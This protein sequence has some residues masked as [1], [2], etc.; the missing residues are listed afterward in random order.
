VWNKTLSVESLQLGAVLTFIEFMRTKASHKF[1]GEK[2]AREMPEDVEALRAMLPLDDVAR[3]VRDS[4][5]EEIESDDGKTT[6]F[7]VELTSPEELDT[8]LKSIVAELVHRLI[9]NMMA[10]A[11]KRDLVDVAYD[12]D[13]GFLFSLTEKAKRLHEANQKEENNDDETPVDD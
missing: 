1:E 5:A 9:S 7:A 13:D 12:D 8:K 10:F 3:I 11:A 4:C 6:F 2:A